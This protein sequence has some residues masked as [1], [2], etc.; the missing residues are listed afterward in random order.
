MSTSLDQLW[1]RIVT[2]QPAAVRAHLDAERRLVSTVATGYR[3]LVEVG[4]ADGSLLL[5]VARRLG[6][7]YLGVDLAAGAVEATR[8]L[9]AD[10]VR[11]D[12]VD[13]A[14]LP[15]PA[16]SL[17]IGYPFNVF[18]NLPDPP[19]A[20]TAAATT[21]ADALVLTYDTSPAATTLRT[22]YYAACDLP[23]ELA[24][25]ETGVHFTSGTFRSSVYHREVV[26]A[27][28]TAAGYRTAV[29]PYG[30]AGLAYHATAA[31]HSP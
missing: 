30:R 22:E 19:R 3:S 13:L 14:T 10:A 17:L 21:G 27:W 20:L 7:E 28:L 12:A 5:P 4:C 1:S 6:L 18:G 25:D 26:T 15:L 31:P 16:G 24:T 29:T 9:G 23:G 8:A 11:A 2:N